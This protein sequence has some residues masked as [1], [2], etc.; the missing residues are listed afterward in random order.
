MSNHVTFATFQDRQLFEHG[1]CRPVH[2]QTLTEAL[3]MLFLG[4]SVHLPEPKLIDFSEVDGG[5]VVAFKGIWSPILAKIRARSEFGDG[6]SIDLQVSHVWLRTSTAGTLDYS[7]LTVNGTPGKGGSYQATIV[8]EKG[9][10][11][12]YS[13]S[14]TPDPLKLIVSAEIAEEWDAFTGREQ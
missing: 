7:Y 1:V 2:G 11:H 12:C 14:A 5:H 9:M 13:V 8:F 3:E 4:A 6:G 10:S